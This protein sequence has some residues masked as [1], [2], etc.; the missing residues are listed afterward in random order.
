MIKTHNISSVKLDIMRFIVGRFYE[1]Y[2][3]N[4][5]LAGST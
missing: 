5:F 4:E 1:T 2:P 3:Q